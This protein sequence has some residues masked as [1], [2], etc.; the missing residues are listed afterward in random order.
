MSIGESE[1]FVAVTTTYVQ[2]AS[3]ESCPQARATRISL[4]AIMRLAREP[5]TVAHWL[6]GWTSTPAVARG[7]TGGRVARGDPENAFRGAMF[8]SHLI[9]LRGP[10]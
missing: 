5:Y 8:E 7:I 10:L 3:P 9:C 4:I 6:A 2:K 1:K